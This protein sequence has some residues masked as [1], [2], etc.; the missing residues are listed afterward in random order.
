MVLLFLFFSAFVYYYV[1]DGIYKNCV[2]LAILF[3]IELLLEIFSSDINDGII[4]IMKMACLLIII[5]YLFYII[6]KIIIMHPFIFIGFIVSILLF[7][8]LLFHHNNDENKEV[9]EE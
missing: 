5:G 1:N 4:Y 8:Y 7:M 3:G 2:P 9:I 6:F